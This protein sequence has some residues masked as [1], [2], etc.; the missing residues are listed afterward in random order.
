[1]LQRRILGL[2]VPKRAVKRASSFTTQYK[3]QPFPQPQRLI[4]FML[5]RTKSGE[6][7]HNNLPNCAN[8][9]LDSTE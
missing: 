4:Q 6:K 3:T 9:T 8:W 2:K 5:F 7:I 1:M